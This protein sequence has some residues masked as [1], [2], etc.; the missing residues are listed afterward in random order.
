MTEFLKLNKLQRGDQVGVISPSS[1]LPEI[2]PAVYELGIKRVQEE[3]GFKPV[4]YPTTKK[5]GSSLED[6]AR[7]IMAAF[8]DVNNKAIF[9]SIGG[10]DQIKL[11]K[12]LDKQVF[13]DNPKPFFGY[14]DNTHLQ[15]F[16]WRLGIPS[17]Y[18][19][20]VMI[21][22]GMNQKM[23]DFT[24][25]YLNHALFDEGEYE[26]RPSDEFS[27]EGLDWSDPSNLDKPRKKEKNDGWYWDGTN[28][29]T[30]IL[31]G[32][33]LESIDYQLRVGVQLPSNEELANTVIFLETSEEIPSDDYVVRV[34]TA[35]GER[36]LLKNFATFLI[37]RPKAWEFDKQNSLEEKKVYKEKQRKACIETI[38]E[39]N[40]DAPIIMN[41][42]F[43]HT[44]P[45]II[46][47]VGRK[48]TIDTSN[49]K[50]TAEY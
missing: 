19:G 28:N 27:D 43:G 24:V 2:F 4:E 46:L 13:L 11:I 23:D 50:I 14:S 17:Y 10:D 29:A 49:K 8:S 3:F 26:L 42:D 47:P 16:L 39:Y 35:L 44:D 32:G 31:W 20:A 22:F 1:G 12:L 30:G 34:M 37:G 25:E 9:A 15:N 38:R 33:C 18:G 48:V 40:T 36:G 7:D 21:Q 45:Q 41:M 6:R 5:M